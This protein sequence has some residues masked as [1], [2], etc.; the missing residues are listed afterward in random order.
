M[1]R[2]EKEMIEDY[3]ERIKKQN[4]KIREDYDRVSAV[5]PK[6]TVERI[7]ALGFTVNGVIK[8]SVL[9]FLEI[10]EETTQPTTSYAPIEPV[11]CTSKE[12]LELKDPTEPKKC[13]TFPWGENEPTAE[14]VQRLIEEKRKN[15]GV[16]K[17]W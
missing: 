11:I 12:V 6:G 2:T 8:D 15:Y 3:K 14:D 13:T 7:K 9:A 4:T 17:E 16:V 5:L 1:A 10:A